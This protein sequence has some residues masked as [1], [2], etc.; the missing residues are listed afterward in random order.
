MPCARVRHGP[1]WLPSWAASPTAVWTSEGR[2]PVTGCSAHAP[3]R[4]R[5]ADSG[6]DIRQVRFV[7][8]G[9]T[10]LIAHHVQVA[11]HDVIGR[12]LPYVLVRV[13]RYRTTCGSPL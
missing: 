12:L 4:C 3:S 7:D 1:G 5:D 2:R 6:K 9:H 13:I 10:E 8:R 11:R